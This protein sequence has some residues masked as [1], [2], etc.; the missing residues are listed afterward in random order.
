MKPEM[1]PFV[2]VCAGDG[3]YRPLPTDGQALAAFDADAHDG[4]GDATWT[5]N[6]D[7]ALTF[8]T[9]EAAKDFHQTTSTVRPLRDDGKPNRPLTMFT[10][11]VGPL[12]AYRQAAARTTGRSFNRAYDRKETS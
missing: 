4:R 12:D 1:G 10:V 5:T 6:P 3:A 9:L 2:I 7:D 8:D 11:I